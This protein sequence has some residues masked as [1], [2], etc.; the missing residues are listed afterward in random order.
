MPATELRHNGVL[1]SPVAT[2]IDHSVAN[3]WCGV[4]VALVVELAGDEL[5]DVGPGDGPADP[6]GAEEAAPN[7]S[8]RGPVAGGE[9]ADDGP[10][11]VRAHDDLRHAD[12]LIVGAA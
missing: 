9:E 2:E 12:D 6:V 7:V 5:D 10:G 11:A 1:R 3:R 8:S 4:E